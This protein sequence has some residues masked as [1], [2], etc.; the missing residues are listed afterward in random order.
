LRRTLDGLAA[1]HGVLRTRL[2]LEGGELVQR[3]GPDGTFAFE[4]A[5]WDGRR[6]EPEET[7][8]AHA[9]RPFDLAE[10]GAARALLLRD[11]DDPARG[12]FQIVLHHA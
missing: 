6:E 2:V 9:S 4:T 12:R 3:V 1:R 8:R 10:P 7:L 5:T 11:A